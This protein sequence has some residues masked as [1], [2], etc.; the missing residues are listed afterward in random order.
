MAI[1]HPTPSPQPPTD[2]PAVLAGVVADQTTGAIDITDAANEAA[3]QAAAEAA[4]EVDARTTDPESTSE[5]SDASRPRTWRRL[6]RRGKRDQRAQ[7]TASAKPAPVA[8]IAVKPTVGAGARLAGTSAPPNPD[9]TNSELANNH[10]ASMVAELREQVGEVMTDNARLQARLTHIER[11]HTEL[12]WTKLSLQ[13]RVTELT[14][15]VDRL[16]AAGHQQ[17]AVLDQHVHILTRQ[18]QALADHGQ[19]LHRH[20][21]ALGLPDGPPRGGQPPVSP[22]PVFRGGRP[23]AIR[24][25]PGRPTYRP[26]AV[27]GPAAWPA[28]AMAPNGPHSISAG[29]SAG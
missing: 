25:M 13:Q 27:P 19:A 4:R 28:G 1:P 26:R 12:R 18:G 9:S 21:Q 2:V 7:S 20:D 10:L 23:A 15:Q 17:D 5:P 11:E 3:S 24:A 22:G 14:R 29:G 6:F 16:A 8:S